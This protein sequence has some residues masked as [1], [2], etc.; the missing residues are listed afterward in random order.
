MKTLRLKLGRRKNRRF[1]G[2]RGRG[3]EICPACGA[4]AVRSGAKYCLIC[5]KVL[6]DDYE[7]LDTI[8][9]SQRM[10]GRSFILENMDR[11]R[12]GDLFQVNRNA[13]SEVAWACFV[14]SLVPYL[15]IL[16]IP[17]TFVI[18]SFGVGM[19]IRAADRG[20]RKLSLLSLGLSVLVLGIQLLLWWLLYIIPE[21]GRRA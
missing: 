2:S 18:G 3:A 14:Y 19:S 5:G 16:F 7:P 17:A 10:Q 21:L 8:R 4:S 9:S 20:G 13:V 12:A 11:N 15:G 1:D 6:E